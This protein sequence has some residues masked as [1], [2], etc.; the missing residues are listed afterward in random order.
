MLCQ[1]ETLALNSSSVA[2]GNTTY[3]WFFDNGSSSVSLGTT[4]VP[5]FFVQNMTPAQNGLYSVVA[6]AGSCAT[7]T[8]NLQNVQVV[9][10]ASL[11]LTNSTD[12]SSPACSNE[13]I[14]L[15]APFIPGATY[16]WTGPLGFSA[17]VHNPVIL[18][19]TPA[20]AG[21]YSVTVQTN[22]CTFT[23]AAP[24]TVYVYST[25]QAKDDFYEIKFNQML[26]RADVTLNDLPGN[27]TDLDISILEQALKGEA[28]KSG[29]LLNYKPER[30][31]FGK[32]QFVYSICNPNCAADCASATVTI[33][34]AGSD[35][36]E[37][38]FVPNV[39]TPNGDG[40]NDF[41]TVP[42]LA[43]TYTNNSVK[44]FNRWG[45]RVFQAKHYKNDW[46][47]KYKGNALPPGTYFYII[48]LDSS[49]PDSEFLQGY[50][51]IIR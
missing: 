10:V 40:A 33:K 1:G 27:L 37:K 11:A 14:Q 42:C 30:N 21:D 35:Q 5:S 7:P 24:T 47:G 17:N 41:F 46:D 36:T 51:T 23:A 4:T 25:L 26:E 22:G 28:S 15:T 29:N 43:D 39:N 50:F 34:V 20:H 49:Q 44:I 31:F 18:S 13:L 6:H 3:E 9:T 2:G 12:A 19:A 16:Q 38:C 32:D 8:S 45:D 48:Q